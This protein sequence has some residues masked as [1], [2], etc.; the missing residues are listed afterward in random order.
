MVERGNLE[1]GALEVTDMNSEKYG[2][3]Q[4][5]SGGETVEGREG[6]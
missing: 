4:S 1:P 3:F 6:S 5:D 2:G